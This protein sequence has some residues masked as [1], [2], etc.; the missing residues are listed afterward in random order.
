MND[1]ALKAIAFAVVAVIA[2][3]SGWQTRGWKE[4]SDAAHRQELKDAQAES[5]RLAVTEIA[6]TTAKAIGGIRITNTTIY[7]KTRHEITKEPMDP[8]CRLPAGWMRNINAARAGADRPEPAA[9][10][11]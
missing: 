6:G 4:D 7:Q 5:V 1:L 9:A 3:G 10:V 8:G 11:P 2:W